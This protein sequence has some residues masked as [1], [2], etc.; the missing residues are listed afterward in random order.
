MATVLFVYRLQGGAIRRA[1]HS[2]GMVKLSVLV[3]SSSGSDQPVSTPLTGHTNNN[4][5]D[6]QTQ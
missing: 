1:G 6:G 3:V 4:W 2:L 5:T